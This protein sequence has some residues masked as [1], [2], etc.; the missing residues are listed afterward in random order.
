MKKPTASQ[1]D[2]WAWRFFSSVG[3]FRKHLH[4]WNGADV[5]LTGSAL[6]SGALEDCFAEDAAAVIIRVINRS[7]NSALIFDFDHFSVCDF[8]FDLIGDATFGTRVDGAL[9]GFVSR[10]FFHGVSLV[11]TTDVDDFASFAAFGQCAA[12]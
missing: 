12:R 1:E 2:W 8:V 6:C 10:D 9:H 11:L 4:G 7:T 5:R 3:L